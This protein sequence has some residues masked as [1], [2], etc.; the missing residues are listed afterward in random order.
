MSDPKI[1][2]ICRSNEAILGKAMDA[3]IM[4]ISH[5]PKT[6]SANFDLHE[7]GT[8]FF[9]SLL[10]T[11][12]IIT[13]GLFFQ[14][15]VNVLWIDFLHV[16]PN[17]SQTHAASLPFL[18]A[19]FNFLLAVI[20]VA[21]TFGVS[22]SAQAVLTRFLL[23]KFGLPGTWAVA[24]SIPIA[25][26]VTWYCFDYLTPSDAANEV[27]DDWRPY[28]HGLTWARYQMICAAQ[29]CVTLFS[30]VQLHLRANGRSRE[31]RNLLL[32]LVLLASFAGAIAGWRTHW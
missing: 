2:A 32:F 16:N 18:F 1:N 31:K 22:Q 23:T 21:L 8:S 10:W 28:Q 15:V 30:L 17:R 25:A 14:L 9:F 5:N 4:A 6:A 3:R 7:V 19:P 24:L 26:V 20:G 12:V 13:A 27:G 11:A 29:S